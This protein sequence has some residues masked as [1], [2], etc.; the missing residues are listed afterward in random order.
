MWSRFVF[1]LLMAWQAI[2]QNS[3]RSMLTALGII[4][5]VASVIAMLAIGKGA[6][7][8][9]E[10]QIKR[11]GLNNIIIT[12]KEM[13]LSKSG[14]GQS[15]PGETAE[16][17]N[18]LGLSLEEARR[19]P[20]VIP[21]IEAVSP[22]TDYEVFA[23]AGNK[24]KRVK[25]IGTSP[26]WFSIHNVE[27]KYGRPYNSDEAGRNL[28]VCVVSQG[29][30]NAFFAGRS[31]LGK[32]IRC[33]GLWLTIVGVMEPPYSGE[34]DKKTEGA[35]AVGA[36]DMRII[37]PLQM[38]MLRFKNKGVIT[39]RSLERSNNNNDDDDGS[40]QITK[41]NPYSQ[42][43]RITIKVSETE[44]LGQVAQLAERFLQRRHANTKDFEVDIP[45]LLLR[46]QQKT[47][48]TFSLVLGLIAGI[49]L[50]VGGIGIMNI[51]L[52]SVTERLKEIGVRRALGARRSDITGQFLIEAVIISVAGG[53]FGVAL[54]V[55]V[56]MGIAAQFSVLTILTPWS[57]GLAFSFAVAVGLI[58]GLAPARKAARQDPVESLRIG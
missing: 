35:P 22:E 1:T 45:E 54:G 52:V 18:S 27:L 55:A 34:S 12:Q 39:R 29:V 53:L 41:P 40:G 9:I 25:M 24:G 5:G 28:P 23:V 17:Q 4:F 10:E 36:E 56:A 20:Q 7:K 57:I 43:N 2:L 15:A 38:L 30:E 8:E 47:R 49:S 42:L 44:Y 46:Q 33:G 21:Y 51:M 6:Q 11:T 26:S 13:S 37:A 50:L 32:T 58:F 19:L 14:A 3:V 16:K 31:A 48:Q